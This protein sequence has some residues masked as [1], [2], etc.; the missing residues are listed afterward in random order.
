MV[1]QGGSSD[2]KVNHRETPKNI[3]QRPSAPTHAPTLAPAPTTR[4]PALAPRT[5]PPFPHSLNPVSLCKATFSNT[6]PPLH[7]T[8]RLNTSLEASGN[9]PK[10]H[11]MGFCA[12]SHAAGISFSPLGSGQRRA[13]RRISL[14]N[15]LVPIILRAESQ[16]GKTSV[17]ATAPMSPPDRGICSKYETL[18]VFFEKF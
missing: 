6:G 12:D 7:S 5:A 18:L 4:A 2:S 9:A 8:D 3:F 14:I 16:V 1:V 10:P 11:G 13:W 17:S 15:Q